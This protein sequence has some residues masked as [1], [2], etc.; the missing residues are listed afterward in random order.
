MESKTSPSVSVMESKTSPS[1]S[2]MESKTTSTSVSFTDFR[3]DDATDTI[4]CRVSPTHRTTSSKTFFGSSEYSGSGKHLTI[5]IKDEGIVHFFRENT[6]DPEQFIKKSISQHANSHNK[7]DPHGL[8]GNYEEIKKVIGQ[9][10][11]ILKLLNELQQAI[12]LIKFPESDKVL[13][14]YF[15]NSDETIMTCNLC[16]TFRVYTKKGMISH[17][18]KCIKTATRQAL[19]ENTVVERVNE[20]G[21]YECSRGTV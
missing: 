19:P 8:K 6:I 17:Q 16:N 5:V 9:K 13:L 12:Y 2:V 21:P 1:V 7:I 18:R 4:R 15:G 14:P 20:R 11:T 10:K 3:I